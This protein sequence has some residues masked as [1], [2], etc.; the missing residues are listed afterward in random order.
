VRSVAEGRG[1]AVGRVVDTVVARSARAVTDAE[2][3]AG[4]ATDG[5]DVAVGRAASWWVGGGATAGVPHPASTPVAS[6]EATTKTLQW[7]GILIW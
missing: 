1:G 5:T 2:A 6:N 4:S 3:V 7:C